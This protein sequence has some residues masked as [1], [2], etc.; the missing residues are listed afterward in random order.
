MPPV[1]I[2]SLTVFPLFVTVFYLLPKA[3]EGV[4]LEDELHDLSKVLVL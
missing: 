3:D 4:Y 2:P 1:V